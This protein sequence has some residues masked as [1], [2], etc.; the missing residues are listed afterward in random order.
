MRPILNAALAAALLTTGPTGAQSPPPSQAALT[1]TA[2]IS[3]VVTDAAT[4]RPLAGASVSLQSSDP[5]GITRVVPRPSMLTDARGRFVL[6]DLPSGTSYTLWASRTGY[7]VG[8]YEGNAPSP[9]GQSV[10][11]P[12]ADGEWKRDANVRMVRFSSIAGRV[13][14]ERGEPVVG[15]A[16]RLFSRRLVA[17]HERLMQGP[18][19]TTDDRGVYRFA[20]IAPGAYFVAVLS[21][22]ATVPAAIA[23][24]SR[25]L[26]L[27]GLHARG[28]APPAVSR[29]EA[30]GASIDAD[31]RHRLVLSSFGTPPPPGADR[32]R[33]Y[34]PV[35]YP[36]AR[37]VDDAQAVE[38]ERGTSR[39]NVDVQLA[40]VS[41]VRVSGHVA[42]DAQDATNMILRLMARGAEHLG[43][44]NEAATTLVE[45]DG[46]F[47]FLSVPAG[48]YTLLGSPAVAEISSGG[49]SPGSLPRAPGAGP[50]MGL[51]SVY[52]AGVGFSAMW[53]RFD[54]GRGV[55]GRLPL[56]VGDADITGIGLPL[57][58]AA[59]VRGRLVFDAAAP[60]DPG[61][62]FPVT[63]EPANGD[64]A[65]G[66][67]N[68][69]TA[70]GDTTYAFTMGGLQGGRYL[71]RIPFPRNVLIASV[72]VNGADVT[73]TGIDGTLGR[74]FDDVVVR[75]T[76]PGAVLS[77]MV[78]DRSGQ[79]A[80][81]AVILF[82]TDPKQWV[83]FGLSP[84]RLLTT[85]AGTGG[86]FKLGL[87]RDGEYYVIAVPGA[88]ATAW[89][90]PRFLA[91][92]AP[93]AS[94]VSLKAGTT[95]TVSLQLSE[96]IVK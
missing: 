29:P 19:V 61:Q 1:G 52:S 21:V 30:G 35:F 40:P 20:Y 77:G 84:D 53:W 22:Q 11:I 58:R 83:D 55:W 28:R 2:A 23:D 78:R 75:V 70:A 18:H 94:R 51:S 71:V 33:V 81:G 79:P 85:T 25:T 65:L 13:V 43:T 69:F 56:S 90:N 76:R 68:A 59:T 42:G 86:G 37:S 34:A 16:V 31:G 7:E 82:P 57:Q 46:S 87:I 92:A 60:P 44:G 12:L 93:Q 26:P 95:S 64:P 49:G 74:D 9:T 36:N 54:A 72:T 50:A 91:A 24:G 8:R 96:V 10:P 4:G 3:G 48:D 62:R 88:Q 89:V 27:G 38:I 45:A 63:L 17:G 15:V 6:V 47:T 5:G 41:A 80:T 14:D 73:D 32:A 66:V 39:A 67:P